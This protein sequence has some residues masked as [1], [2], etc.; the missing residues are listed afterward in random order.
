MD[1]FLNDSI[2]CFDGFASFNQIYR[3]TG[4]INYQTGFSFGHN[5]KREQPIWKGDMPKESIK[6]PLKSGF[7]NLMKTLN[8]L[9]K[10]R[11][12]LHSFRKFEYI[13]PKDMYQFFQLKFIKFEKAKL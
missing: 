9:Q 4:L 7:T 11:I 13:T 3:S 8:D 1:A 5:S 12:F 10:K 6:C 2:G